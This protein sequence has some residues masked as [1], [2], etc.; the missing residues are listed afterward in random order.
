MIRIAIILMTINE[1]GVASFL[2]LNVKS[3]ILIRVV[4]FLRLFWSPLDL[5]MRTSIMSTILRQFL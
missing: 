3:P 1:V 5:C 2:T 4:K